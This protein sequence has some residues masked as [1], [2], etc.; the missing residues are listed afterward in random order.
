[1]RR[2][3][4]EEFRLCKRNRAEFFFLGIDGTGA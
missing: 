4:V 3:D 1:M 2:K